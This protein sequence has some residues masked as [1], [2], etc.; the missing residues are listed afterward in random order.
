[1]AESRYSRYLCSLVLACLLSFF[2]LFEIEPQIRE[3]FKFTE[4]EDV[5]ANPNFSRH[6]MSMVDMI[7]CAVGFLGPDLDPFRSD[8]LELG[9]RHKAYG[10]SPH[11]FAFMERALF[12]ALD[13]IL[14]NSFTVKERRSW[15]A[16]FD[17]M[18]ANMEAGLLSTM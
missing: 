7:D 14:G 8:L 16:V 2:R 1:M 9:A 17:F 10:A 18:V 11:Y 6:A 13:E 3:V 12:F 15:Q 5:R 4:G